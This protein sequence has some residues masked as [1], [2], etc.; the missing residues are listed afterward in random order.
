MR[1]ELSLVLS[2]PSF[3]FT[4]WLP[5][6]T[7]YVETGSRLVHKC[8]H[9]ADKTGQNCPVSN[10]LKNCLRLSQTQFTPPTRQDKTVLS[11]RCRRCELAVRQN[12]LVQWT[13]EMLT[14]SAYLFIIS[15]YMKYTQHTRNTYVELFHFTTT[16]TFMFF[17][18]E[19]QIKKSNQFSATSFL[20]IN[21][22]I[23]HFIVKKRHDK[24]HT[25]KKNTLHEWSNVN[26]Y[27]CMSH[28][29]VKYR[30]NG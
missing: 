26:V 19:I 17:S 13:N 15:S 2:W 16:S 1:C 8:V 21:Q 18:N 6:V 23:N 5:I 28:Q 22:S 24:K 29:H 20:T 30:N 3:Q 11:C 14:M 10:I 4:M 12:I 9:T 27:Q 7:L 25:N